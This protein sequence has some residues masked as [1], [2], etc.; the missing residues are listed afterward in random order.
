MQEHE[1]RRHRHQGDGHR[2]TDHL[3]GHDRLNGEGP[4]ATRRRRPGREP[5]P[6]LQNH[7]NENDDPHC[8]VGGD[9]LGRPLGV[10]G[11]VKHDH[12]HHEGQEEGEEG[13]KEL[14]FLYE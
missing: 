12:R 14:P 6:D 2:Y 7:D 13:L 10:G 1:H 11:H 4:T 8:A 3:G 9:V 5:D